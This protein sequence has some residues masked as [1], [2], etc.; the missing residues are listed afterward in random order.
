MTQVATTTGCASLQRGLAMT[1]GG[2][3]SLW[4]RR[5]HQSARNSRVRLVC[6]PHAGGSAS[7]YRPMSQA[8]APGVEVLAVQYPGRQD[9]RREPCLDSIAELAD[10]VSRVLVDWLDRPCAFF[11]HS[12]G[13][14]LAFEVARRIEPQAGA[15]L[16][17]LFASGRRAPSRQRNDRI[18]LLD[19]AALV[20]QLVRVGGTDRV[21]LDDEELRAMILPV[22]R[23]DYRAIETYGYVPGAPLGCPIT[24]L[25]GDR[26][27]TVTMDEAS[28]WAEHCTGGFDLRTFPGGHFYLDQHRTAVTDIIA[29]T[30][31]APAQR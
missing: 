1:S 3:G 21:F 5:Y 8:L 4:I 27:P 15:E 11:G 18:H 10:R 14:T 2:D 24:T 16:L 9:R 17:C 28:A 31:A 23:S 7:Y 6:F 26:D 29:A 12:M 19:D 20:A 30:L 25:I 13:A 22:V